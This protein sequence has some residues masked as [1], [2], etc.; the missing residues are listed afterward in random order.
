MSGFPNMRMPDMWKIVLIILAVLYL[1]SPY[2]LLPDLMIGWGW[3]DDMVILGFLLR[4]FYMQ[5]KKRE[6]F[7]KYYQ[8]GQGANNY[9]QKTAGEH[10]SRSPG[11]ER[12]SAAAWDPYQ[13]LGIERGASQENIKHAFR[14]L[15]GKY[16]PDKVAHLGPEFARI[17]E[18]KILPRL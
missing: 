6:A 3:L 8:D 14:Q 9:D 13:I 18:E 7:R 1:L 5:K 10:E 17:S 15:A 2:D 4:Y 12:E 16:H 11:N